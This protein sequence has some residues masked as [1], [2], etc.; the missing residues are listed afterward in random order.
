MALF[1]GWC[2][3]PGSGRKRGWSGGSQ[4]LFSPACASTRDR[5]GE[6]DPTL[7][8]SRTTRKRARQLGRRG[9]RPSAKRRVERARSGGRDEPFSYAYFGVPMARA[10]VWSA[11]IGQETRLEWRVPVALQP[12]LR[13]DSGPT[14]RARPVP[15]GVDADLDRIGQLRACV[16]RGWQPSRRLRDGWS[17]CGLAVDRDPLDGSAAALATVDITPGQVTEQ[18]LP[19]RRQRSRRRR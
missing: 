18:L 2:G 6:R 9:Q 3:P 11:R 5:R 17:T 16:D 14:G 13:I 8:V 4:L 12:C 15:V 19:G 10:V 1:S 7:S